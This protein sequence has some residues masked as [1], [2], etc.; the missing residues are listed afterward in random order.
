MNFRD[1]T[2]LRWGYLILFDPVLGPHGGDFDQK[3]FWK[4]KCPTYAR[5][6]PPSGL[7]LIGALD[8]DENLWWLGLQWHQSC[9]SNEMTPLPI[10]LAAIFLTGNCSYKIVHGICKSVI[11]TFWDEVFIV[12]NTVKKGNSRP[13]S[14]E[15]QRLLTC[16]FTLKVSI[17]LKTCVKDHGDSSGQLHKEGFD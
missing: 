16:N 4:V 15:N 1:I 5:G 7:T 8:K 2:S 9:H 3:I 13:L 17:F 6:P 10:I 12:R 14:E 11:E